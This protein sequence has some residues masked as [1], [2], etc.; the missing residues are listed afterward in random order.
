MARKIYQSEGFKVDYDKGSFDEWCVYLEDNEKRY[1]PSDKEYFER[2]VSLGAKHGPEQ[3]YQDFLKIF[4]Q[5][6][7]AIDERTIQTI[8]KLSE[9]YR[10]DSAEI[11]KWFLV[12]YAGMVAEENKTNTRLGKRIKRLGIYQVLILK[13]PVLH[14]ANYSKRRKWWELDEIMRRYGF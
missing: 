2:L 9:K 13:R 8:E 10:E 14:A 12:I 6:S 4:Q 3:I 11:K 1:A 7:S 5:T